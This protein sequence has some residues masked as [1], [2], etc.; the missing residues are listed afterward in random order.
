MKGFDI[1][2]AGI[3]LIERTD[4]ADELYHIGFATMQLHLILV[5]FAL[6][7]YLVHKQQ[8]ALRIAVYHVKVGQTVD[9]HQTFLQF[10]ERSHDER[11]RRTDVV[12]GINEKTH[13]ASSSSSCGDVRTG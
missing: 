7:Q 10:V 4:A 2:L 11:Q 3:K 5:N 1:S 8:Q 6:I 13:F 12:S 9:I